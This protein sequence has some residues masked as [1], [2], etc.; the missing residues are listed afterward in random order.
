MTGVGAVVWI[1]GTNVAADLRVHAFMQKFSNMEHLV[2]SPDFCPDGIGFDSAAASTVRLR[3]VDPERYNIP[4]HD[5]QEPHIRQLNGDNDDSHDHS[6]AQ[7]LPEGVRIA[8]RGHIVQLEPKLELNE[9]QIISPLNIVEVEKR[10]SR[11]VL[12]DAAIA[13]Q[14][15]KTCLDQD[16]AWQSSLPDSEAEIITLGTG[17]ALP[18]KYRN[19][20]STLVRVPGWGSLLFDCGENTL[21]QLRRVFSGEELR[22]VLQELK[23]IFI[24][25]MHADH[26]LGSASVIKA[27]YEEVHGCRPA[28]VVPRDV[29]AWATSSYHFRTSNDALAC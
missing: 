20:S 10:I 8:K 22:Q 7:S 24:S 14:A 3:K 23:L 27:W 13:Q 18:S 15:T 25:H 9:K 26:H 2:S 21:G 11:K 12:D 28:P 16:L 19:V 4:V 1:C 6:N 29:R 17:S 5:S